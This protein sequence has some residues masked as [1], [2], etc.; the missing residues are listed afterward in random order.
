LAEWIEYNLALASIELS[1]E[2]GAFPAYDPKL[3]RPTWTTARPFNELMK[4]SNMKGAPSAK[5]M[6]LIED[7]PT[8]DW[9]YVE[10]LRKKY[11]IRNATLTSIAP[12]GTIS[13]IANTSSSIEPIFAVAF[14][15][16]VSVGTF[17][18]IDRLFLEYL[19][20]YELDDPKLIETIAER[21]SIS[22]MYFLPKSIKELFKIAYDIDVK[23][24]V[25]HQAVWQQW[26]CAGV[27]KTINMRF[28]ASIDD[29]REAYILAWMLGC[30]G[31]TVYRDKS[32][33]QQVIYVGV[34]MQQK[35][36]KEALEH[37]AGITAKFTDISDA[38]ESSSKTG[39][40][41]CEY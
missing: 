8:V 23:Y 6:R 13:I 28:E 20:R 5:V 16:H 31:I 3:Y 24:H 22:D 34:K 27:S 9:N 4:I 17:I 14:E 10:E 7:R 32:K 26:V 12:T 37:K 25:L 30:K 40:Q 41:L 36:D 39:C 18:E 1:K 33:T 2:R 21:G 29:V 19:K 11:G 38:V 35:E 15:K